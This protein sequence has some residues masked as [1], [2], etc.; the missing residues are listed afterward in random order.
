VVRR[1]DGNAARPAVKER[2][3]DRP[4]QVGEGGHVH[5]GVVNEDRIE[6]PFE[7]DIAHVTLNVLALEIEA[8]AQR[9]HRF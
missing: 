4:L 2:G 7:P 8:A 1:E 6:L 3:L 9:E 5:D